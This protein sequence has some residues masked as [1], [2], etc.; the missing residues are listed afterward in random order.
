M[1][2]SPQSPVGKKET[3]YEGP[4]VT[5]GTWR[6]PEAPVAKKEAK[7]ET[8]YG[9]PAAASKGT[10]FDERTFVRKR[11]DNRAAVKATTGSIQRA[12][13]RFFI[14]AGITLLEAVYLGG[15]GNA[16]S[17]VAAGIVVAVFTL[18]GIFAYRKSKAA[19][20]IGMAIYALDTV[21]LVVT[22]LATSFVLVAYAIVIHCIVIYRLYLAY[23]LIRDLEM[24]EA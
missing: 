9:G 18:L 11:T 5:P 15:S 1:S 13:L 16:V 10:M 6:V 8:I 14:V 23:G 12:S 22:G 21:L 24:A 20:L 7:E 19:F 17:T 4:S 3:M 2:N